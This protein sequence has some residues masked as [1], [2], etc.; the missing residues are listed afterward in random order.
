MSMEKSIAE[1]SIFSWIE[2]KLAPIYCTSEE[3]IYNEMESQS[4][5]SLPIIYKPFDVTKNPIGMI[6]DVCMIFFIQLREKEKNY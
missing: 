4:G 3:F 6:E 2:E 5:Y 1:K